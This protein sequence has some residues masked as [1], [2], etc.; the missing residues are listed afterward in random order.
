MYTDA[1]KRSYSYSPLVLTA[2]TLTASLSNF[3]IIIPHTII[4]CE[5]QPPLLLLQFGI[6]W[7]LPKE[8]GSARL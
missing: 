2:V 1:M 5:I 3:A 4:S 6:T 8:D 7:P